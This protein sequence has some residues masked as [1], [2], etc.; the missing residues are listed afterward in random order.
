MNKFLIALVATFL[1]VNALAQF[2]VEVSGAGL[3]QFPIAVA[4]FKGNDGM[5]Q[6]LATIVL[7]DLE[8]SGQFRGVD[9]RGRPHGREHSSGFAGVAQ[10]GR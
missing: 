7:A 6:K 1:G 9:N 5:T 3:T 10:T 2:R 8:R 4:P